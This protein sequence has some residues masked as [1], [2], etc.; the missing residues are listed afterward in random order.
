MLGMG[1]MV[2]VSKD[3]KYGINE[4]SGEE[5]AITVEQQPNYIKDNLS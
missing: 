2:A 4:F 3:W 1:L 5:E